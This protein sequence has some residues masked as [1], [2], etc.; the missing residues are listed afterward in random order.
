[1]D[2]NFSL[3]RIIAILTRHF[4]ELESEAIQESQLS[5]L[6]MKQIVY[7][8]EI[9]RLDQPTFGDLARVFKVSK[10]SVTAIVTRLIQK[11]YLT[12]NQSLTDK[13]AFNIALTEKG[14]T[15]QQVHAEF[16]RRIARQFAN[17]LDPDEQ[18]T[19]ARLL[20]KIVASE[21]K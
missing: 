18:E 3:D 9:A 12:K 20:S 4:A 7:L 17:I 1:M 11:G 2:P 5:E 16:H 21:M 13:R 6:S 14:R 19:L 8:E 10:P 15:L